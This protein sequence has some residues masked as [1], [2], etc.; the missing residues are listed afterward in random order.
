VQETISVQE[1]V[2]SPMQEIPKPMSS[3][4][5]KKQKLTELISIEEKQESNPT[6]VRQK[7]TKKDPTTTTPIAKTPKG[8][9]RQKVVMQ[10]ETLV[11]RSPRMREKVSKDSTLSKTSTR[12]SPMQIVFDHSPP[13]RTITSI[14]EN[15]TEECRDEIK[16][17]IDDT[18]TDLL[19][20]SSYRDETVPKYFDPNTT[21]VPNRSTWI[22]SF[23]QHLWKE[24]RK[25]KIDY[26]EENSS[27]TLKKL[28]F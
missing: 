10:E 11:R 17:N 23:V 24:Q 8:K 19:G 9:S 28:L 4:A 25:R 1:N 18:Q 15:P 27:I 7:R 22:T 5:K 16:E 12:E 26:E 3:K 2:R 13:H 6:I 14:L 21:L 20:T